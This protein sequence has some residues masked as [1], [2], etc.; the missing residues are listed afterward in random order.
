MFMDV[1]ML[2][3][4]VIEHSAGCLSLHQQFQV[5]PTVTPQM[6]EEKLIR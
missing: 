2:H 4:R 1:K 3:S 6:K 5:A